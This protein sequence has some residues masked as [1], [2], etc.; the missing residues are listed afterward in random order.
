MLKRIHG[1][2]QLEGEATDLPYKSATLLSE[3]GVLFCLQGA[4][5][6]EAMN[7]RNLPFIAG[8]SMAYG[9]TEEQAVESISLSPCKIMG[10][11]KDYGSLEIDKKATFFVSR[12]NALDM[13]TNKV[14]MIYFDGKSESTSNFQEALYLKYKA[15]YSER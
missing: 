5:D 4:G 14:T 15:K 13:M 7:A 9:L 1:L 8:T 2:P 10:I 3:Q 12:G 6:M 11:D